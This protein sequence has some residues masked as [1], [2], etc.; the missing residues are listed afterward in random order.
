MS[1]YVIDIG[2]EV[3]DTYINN[4]VEWMAKIVDAAHKHDTVVI[5]IF[6]PVAIEELNY[7]GKKFIDIL[8]DVCAVNNWPK[9]KF[10]FETQNLIQDVSVW[11]GTTVPYNNGVF[12]AGQS[13]PV[14]DLT[15]EFTRTFGML[16]NRSTWDRLLIASNLYNEHKDISFQKYC[17][18]LDNPMHMINFDFD[19]MLWQSSSAGILNETLLKQVANF[20]SSLPMGQH[21]YE[22]L[23][24]DESK[25]VEHATGES[26]TSF[27]K[28]FFIDIVSEK[29]ITGKVLYFTEKS[30]RP[31]MTMNPFI[32][33]ASVGHLD[34]LRKLGFKTFRKYWSEDYDYQSGVPRINSIQELCAKLSRLSKKEIEQM[35][36][37]MKPMLEHNRLHYYT[38]SV[39][40]MH[41]TFKI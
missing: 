1:E 20:M 7:K 24:G 14:Q 19:R 8:N 41:N 29:M 39:D 38:L 4:D 32:T 28:N 16:V 40:K 12:L 27:Y 26:V 35:Y 37:D 18:S 22:I 11:P 23:K 34:G 31:L 10:R 13:Q 21:V 5:K 15:K 6:E 3:E 25:I 36:D 17:N 9:H 33:N 30:A 2:V